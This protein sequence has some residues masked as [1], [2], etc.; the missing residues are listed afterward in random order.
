MEKRL[1]ENVIWYGSKNFN[2]GICLQEFEN[3]ELLLTLNQWSQTRGPRTS[4]NSAGFFK[5]VDNLPIFQ[6]F[7]DFS[8]NF[9]FTF[10]QCSQRDLSLSLMRPESHSEFETPDLNCLDIYDNIFFHILTNWMQSI[11]LLLLCLLIHRWHHFYNKVT[12]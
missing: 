7:L 12:I 8:W 6:L 5:F 4:K 1:C 3:G 9:F 10:F 2:A 11:L